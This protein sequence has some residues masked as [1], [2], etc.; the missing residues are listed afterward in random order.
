MSSLSDAAQPV[1]VIVRLTIREAQ[2]RRLLWIGL[3]LGV[4]FITVFTIG[5]Y[6]IFQD[7]QRFRGNTPMIAESISIGFLTAGL[8]VSNFLVIMVTVL[9]S[10][11]SISSEIADNTI[12]A[13]AAKPLHRW[14]IVLGKWIGHAVLLAIYAAVLCLGL[15]TAVWAISGIL[16]PNVPGVV[17]ILILE[18]L[19]ALSLTMLG[20]TMFS[21]LANGVVAFML[22]GV[23]FVGGW[24]EQIGTAFNSQTAVDLGILSSLLMPS[25]ALWRYAAAIMQPP[26]LAGVGAATVGPMGGLIASR[27]SPAFLVYTAIY[28]LGLLGAAMWS[29]NR[30]DF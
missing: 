27:P 20:S 24:V 11:G 22:Y 10:V 26:G 14:Q 29:F 7:L 25:E 6:F 12:H 3:A 19:T 21:T 1:G 17:S 30:R 9:T 18:S 15:I 16:P 4:V 8:Y 23:A 28:V 5:F 13:I 2:R